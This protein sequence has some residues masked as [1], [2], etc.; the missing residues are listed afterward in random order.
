MSTEHNDQHN[1]K[2]ESSGITPKPIIMF[3]VILTVSTIMVFF[4]VKGLLYGFKKL[5][6]ANQVQPVTAMPEGRERK[7]PPEPRLQGAPGAD[8][9]MSALPLE[10]M[11]EYRERTNQKAN[12]YGWVV[13]ESGVVRLPL[14]RAKEVIVDRGLP[15]AT[16][17]LTDEV[18]KAVAARKVFLAAESSAG[19]VL[20]E[21][22]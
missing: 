13:K 9:Q 18:Q 5:D 8:N 15:L 20:K 14:E 3:L 11:R 16:E 12:S 21:K 17:K 2:P 1:L 4:I 6:E 19:R 22:E 10:E 7:L